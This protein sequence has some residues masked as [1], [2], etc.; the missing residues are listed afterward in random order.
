MHPTPSHTQQNRCFL[1]SAYRYAFNS[2]E[3]DDEVKGGGNS[4]TTE[5]R[6]YDPRLGRWLTLDPLFS[7][8]PWQSPYCSF[9]NNPILV[10]DPTGLAGENSSDP[11]PKKQKKMLEK[12]TE[13][14]KKADVKFNTKLDEYNRDLPDNE[15][16]D[17]RQFLDKMIGE[18][19]NGGNKDPRWLR[20]YMERNGFTSITGWQT[21]NVSPVQVSGG[22]FIN[23]NGISS[24]SRSVNVP[25]NTGEVYVA[26]NSSTLGGAGGIQN[27]SVNVQIINPNGTILVNENIP[28]VI[29]SPVG[30]EN[31]SRTIPYNNQI[32]GDI[33]VVITGGN[34]N[35]GYTVEIRP[36]NMS[37]SKAS[38]TTGPN[39][40]YKKNTKGKKLFN[41]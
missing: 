20:N 4:Y 1:S 41:K 27:G 39:P 14:R 23:P 28:V 13:K 26:L 33:T 5:F 17:R 30:S 8:F 40:Q 36:D 35:T 10:I 37:N 24:S 38:T 2:M 9:D 31:S 11:N 21:S 16:L 19:N 34:F 25:F 12:E 29:N 18:S 15:K 22:T 6:Q 7:N 32:N 3:K